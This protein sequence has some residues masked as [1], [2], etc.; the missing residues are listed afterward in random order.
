M[1]LLQ[2]QLLVVAV[3]GLLPELFSMSAFLLELRDAL[4]EILDALLELLLLEDDLT[5]FPLPVKHFVLFFVDPTRKKEVK[6]VVVYLHT[7]VD[8]KVS[9]VKRPYLLLQA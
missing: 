6:C 2:R 3:L 8:I 1:E 5:L 4:V 9:L 7:E